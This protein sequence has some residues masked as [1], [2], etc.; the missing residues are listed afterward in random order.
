MPQLVA[1]TQTPIGAVDTYNA[2]AGACSFG[3]EGLLVLLSQIWLETGSG[4]SC[5][6]FNL[7]GI[8]STGGSD[9]FDWFQSQTQEGS[10]GS[11]VTITALF[12]AYDSLDAGAADFVHLLQSRFAAAW[13]AAQTGD[14]G[15]YAQA[16]H[17]GGYYT[18]SETDYAAGLATRYAQLDPQIPA[19]APNRGLGVALKVGAILAV[20]AGAAWWLLD[21]RA[22][23]RTFQSLKGAFA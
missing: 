10:G 19:G 11:A 15:A 6:N 5:F 18:A 9:G 12:R 2:L 14:T 17:D 16:L 20:S 21:P 22:V 8:K 4:A 7:G 13:A 1:R 23:K 3:R